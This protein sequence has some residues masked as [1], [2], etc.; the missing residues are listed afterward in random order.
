MR[1]HN[2]IL[3]SMVGALTFPAVLA[4]E[5]PGDPAGEWVG[6]A[7]TPEMIFELVVELEQEDG[8][9][10]GAMQGPWPMPL[11][12]VSLDDSGMEIVLPIGARIEGDWEDGGVDGQ[13]SWADIEE[14]LRFVPMSSEEGQRQ[15]EAAA[16]T[17]EAHRPEPLEAVHEGEGREGL[18]PE[19]VAELVAAADES[20]S[21]GLAMFHE[22]GLVGEWYAGGQPQAVESMSVTKPILSLGVGVLLEEGR[23]E[24]LDTP[25]HEFYPQWEKGDHAEVTLRHLLTH[26]SGL[27]R[28]MD[29]HALNTAEDRVALAL[30]S[31]IVTA[32]G[33]KTQYNNNAMNLLAG[34]IGEAAGE[35]ADEYLADRVF[36]PLGIEDFEWERDEAGNPQGQAGLSIRAGDLARLGQLVLQEGV[37]DGERLVDA[38]FLEKAVE[39]QVSEFPQAPES[40]IGLGWMLLV[41]EDSEDPGVKAVHHNGDLGQYLLILPDEELVA[42]RMVAQSKGYDPASD[43]LQ[44]FYQ[45]VMEKFAGRE[46]P[47]GS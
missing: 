11:E 47:A 45:L 28:A 26:T 13:F 37:W 42:V 34:V 9:W 46:G 5:P 17:R 30:E 31:D 4:A 39:P 8:E 40:S 16:E 43:T 18:E 7:K 44:G 6:V 33:E 2:S 19:A 38:G 24:S 10:T 20:G 1:T 32:P 29:T 41:D 23:I 25:V 15:L 14:P 3:A 35:P 21:T 22:G 12:S 27:G 36:A